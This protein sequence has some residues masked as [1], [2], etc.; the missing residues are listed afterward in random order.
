MDGLSFEERGRWREAPDAGLPHVHRGERCLITNR[1][2]AE[3]SPALLRG[4]FFRRERD[5]LQLNVY[6]NQV[7]NEARHVVLLK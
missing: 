3:P 2:S 1:T 6:A 4:T 5:S 7:V